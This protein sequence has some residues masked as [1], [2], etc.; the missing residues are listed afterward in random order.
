MPSE[1]WKVGPVG[2]RLVDVGPVCR[3]QWRM[4]DEKQGGAETIKMLICVKI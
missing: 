3:E 2:G 1:F 4:Q